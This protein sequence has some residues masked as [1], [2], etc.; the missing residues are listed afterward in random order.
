MIKKNNMLKINKVLIFLVCII[1]SQSIAGQTVLLEE[2]INT[3][4]FKLP[5]K[6]PNFRHFSHLY[7]G[8]GLFIPEGKELEVKIKPGTSISFQFGWR[9]KLKLTNWLAIGSGVNYTNDIFDIKQGEDKI[10]PNDIQH[11]REKFKFNNVGSEFYFRFNFGKR[12]NII[13]RFIDFGAYANWTFRVK[14]IYIDKAESIPPYRA[15]TQKVVFHNLNY[16]EKFNYGL[17]A[18]IGLN[19]YVL[20]AN[21][22][23]T[24]LFTNEYRAEVGAYF[25]PKI[26]V[27][28]EMGLHK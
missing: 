26:S 24:E 22:R 7:I 27:G 8:A 6:G 17:K 14:H 19:R 12:G 15:G 28:L 4:D 1:V 13:G 11:S 3:Y 21:Y 25:L 18:R 20:S 9:Y 16:V 23:L 5:K 2:K 10:I